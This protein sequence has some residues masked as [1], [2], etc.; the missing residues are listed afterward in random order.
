M[1]ND[2]ELVK[3]PKRYCKRER[4][5]DISESPEPPLKYQC[6]QHDGPS[7]PTPACTAKSPKPDD[8]PSPRPKTQPQAR[9]QFSSAS[10]DSGPKP[11]KRPLT[12]GLDD[13]APRTEPKRRRQSSYI[14]RSNTWFL[15]NWLNSSCPSRSEGGDFLALE[16]AGAVDVVL[17]TE[18]LEDSVQMSQPDLKDTQASG[19]VGS[20]RLKT[21]SPLYRAAL[22]M[23]GVVLD[24]FGTKMPRDVQEMVTKHMRKER[25]SPRI[26][27]NEKTSILKTI[28]EA[29]DTPELTVSDIIAPPL[30]PVS[31]VGLAQGRDILWSPKPIPQST[32]YPLV[33]PKT[34]RHFGFRPTLKSDWTRAELAAADDAK[35]RPY[36]QP[37]RENLFPS[38]L[39]EVK[40]EAMGGTLYAAEG[41]LATAGFHRVTSLMWIL[42]QINPERTRSSCDALVFSVAVTQ[43]EAV[44]HVHYYNPQDDTFYMS[45]IDSFYFAKDVQGCR[46]HIKNVVEWLLEIQQPIVRDALKALHPI[47]KAWKK[48]R[49]TGPATDTADFSVESD[50]GRSS[51]SR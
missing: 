32:D 22:K 6:V 4:E 2:A 41:Q 33:K 15:D 28:E 16:R 50:S 31:D 37:T 23:N 26:G 30:F 44:A 36:S 47:A 38:F 9:R 19:S 35:V 25:K 48:I 34:D 24:N 12:K 51:K 42:D 20:E 40:S 39:V 49:S 21:S 18:K 17:T 11:T 1:C 46:D 13:P 7:L 43:R 5:E 29:W 8:S 27:D 3:P 14:Q 10:A 45:Y